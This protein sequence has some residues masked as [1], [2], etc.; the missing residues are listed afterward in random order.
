[1]IGPIGTPSQIGKARQSLA[2]ARRGLYSLL[3]QDA[4][5]E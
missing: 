4:N 5:D 2:D 1:V 3:A